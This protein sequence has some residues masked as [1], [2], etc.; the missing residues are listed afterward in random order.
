MKKTIITLTVL[1]FL[2]IITFVHTAKSE[3]QVV[4]WDQ[5]KEIVIKYVEDNKIMG[6]Y[7]ELKDKDIVE[8]APKFRGIKIKG[9]GKFLGLE[10]EVTPSGQIVKLDLVTPLETPF[11]V[12]CRT[13][14]ADKK[15]WDKIKSGSKV[16]FTGTVNMVGTFYFKK[17]LF[18]W[19][20]KRFQSIAINILSVKPN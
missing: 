11:T 15:L 17:K 6:K 13:S 7:A 8:I 18:G 3:K 14:S 10:Q 5:F 20:E 4:T 12:T 16:D 1:C 9:S 2:S 19:Q